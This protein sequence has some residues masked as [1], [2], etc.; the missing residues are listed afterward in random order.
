MGGSTCGRGRGVASC[1]LGEGE[2]LV[3]IKEGCL[4]RT[5][6]RVQIDDLESILDEIYGGDEA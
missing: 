4:A 2:L 3:E 1:S 6:P 5:C